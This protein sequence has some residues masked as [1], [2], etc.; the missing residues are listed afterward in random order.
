MKPQYTH[1]ESLQQLRKYW[2]AQGHVGVPDPRCSCAFEG[3]GKPN[4]CE[5]E[6]GKNA[7]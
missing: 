3:P 7:N 5:Y 4:V 6:V 2:I 1:W